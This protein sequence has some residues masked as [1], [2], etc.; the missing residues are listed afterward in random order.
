MTDASINE[1]VIRSLFAHLSDKDFASA[2]ALLREDVSW[3]LMFD[4][5]SDPHVGHAAV[6]ANV[7][8]GATTMFRP[9]DPRIIVDAVVAAGDRVMAETR[10]TG[11]RHDG[12]PYRNRYAWAFELRDGK[13]Q[14]AREYMDS[15]YVSRFFV[16]AADDLAANASGE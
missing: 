10:G 5:A 14:S 15:L 8:A 7:F 9:G 13:V 11:E 6:L 16:T 4:G 2:L 3:T 12:A 1:R